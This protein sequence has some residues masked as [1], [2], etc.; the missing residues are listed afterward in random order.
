M[1]KPC[2]HASFKAVLNI[3]SG[4]MVFKDQP[5]REE[6]KKI[7][8]FLTGA[9]PDSEEYD[10][11]LRKV[12]VHL[13]CRFE[14]I[15][16]DSMRSRIAIFE[17]QILSKHQV[18]SE[19]Y[20]KTVNNWLDHMRK[21]GFYDLILKPIEDSKPRLFRAEITPHDEGIVKHKQATAA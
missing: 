7:V 1:A 12:R 13:C 5:T 21:V 16:D 19:A 17:N 15:W 14:K 2:F 4:R 20:M 9:K 6:V 18:G 8:E 10:K 11:G 3:M